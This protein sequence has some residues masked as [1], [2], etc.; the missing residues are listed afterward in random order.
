VAE[1]VGGFGIPHNPHFPTLVEQGAPLGVEIERLYGGVA[2]RLWA[3][4]PDAILFVTSDHY[5]IFWETLPIF[6]TVSTFAANPEAICRP[7]RITG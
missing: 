7:S 5:N 1:I 2:E 3:T 4:A 6:S